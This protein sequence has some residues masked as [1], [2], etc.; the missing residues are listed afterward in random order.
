MVLRDISAL[1][2]IR[3]LRAENP[4]RSNAIGWLLTSMNAASAD[5]EHVG[6][7]WAAPIGWGRPPA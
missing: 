7:D 2:V 1:D 4:R 3:A 6:I 5:I